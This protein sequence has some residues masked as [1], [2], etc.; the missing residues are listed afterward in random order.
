MIAKKNIEM[1]L[2]E[3]FIIAEKYV[4]C[5]EIGCRFVNCQDC[6]FNIDMD[7]MPKVLKVLCE[8]AKRGV[9]NEALR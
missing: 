3:A 5:V 8:A 1:T 6:P 7:D 4:K 9:Q 2:E